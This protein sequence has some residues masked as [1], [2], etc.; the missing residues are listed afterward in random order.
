[1]MPRGKSRWGLLH[2]SAAVETES[3]PI[4]VKKTMEPPVRM[5]GQ[6]FG[7]KGC[8]LDVW[9]KRDAKV[10]KARIAMILISTMM[11]LVS[12]DSRMPRTRITVSNITMM[13]AGQLKPKLQPGP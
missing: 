3:K 5:P 4:Y 8:Q 13:K 7:E 2:S 12:A 1:M 6:P 9:M 11:L 10:T